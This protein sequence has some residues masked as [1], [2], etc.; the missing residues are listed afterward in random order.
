V[1]GASGRFLERLVVAVLLIG[2]APLLP[3]PA[4]LAVI[5]MLLLPMRR[6][7]TALLA[8]GE[9]TALGLRKLFLA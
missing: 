1:S 3:A 5:I 9:A 2:E 7:P 4:L 6:A 8:S